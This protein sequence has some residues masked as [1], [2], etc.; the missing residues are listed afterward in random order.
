MYVVLMAGGLTL[1]QSKVLILPT[2]LHSLEIKCS[3]RPVKLNTIAIT[4]KS[5]DKY[6]VKVFNSSEFHLSEMICYKIHTLIHIDP[7]I[8]IEIH[9]FR[10]IPN[11]S[12]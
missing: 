8:S 7:E 1:F 3:G 6:V 10:D 5:E 9:T 4:P 11:T 2:A 12:K